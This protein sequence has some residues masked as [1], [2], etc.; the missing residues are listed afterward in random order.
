MGKQIEIDGRSRLQAETL[1]P[2]T[3]SETTW[4]ILLA[5]HSE[6]T[7][8]MPLGRIARL[9][10]VPLAALERSL[11]FLEH[12]NLV[13]GFMIPGSSELIAVLTPAGD[14]MVA[15]YASALQQAQLGGE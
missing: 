15:Q 14:A 11:R 3:L 5:L 8:M 10:S 2:A 12:R 4:D 7:G 1:P 9:V 13:A 6:L